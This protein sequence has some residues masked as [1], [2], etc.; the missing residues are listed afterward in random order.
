MAALT[1]MEFLQSRLDAA[2]RD[3]E[4]CVAAAQLFPFRAGDIVQHAPSGETWI[5][6]CDQQGN[7]VIPAGWPESMARAAHCRLVKAG[8]D[9]ERVKMLRLAAKSGGQRASWAQTQLEAL[10]ATDPENLSP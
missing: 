5:L 3:L 6:A 8:T 1:E 9:L 4:F 2:L 7:D 10:A